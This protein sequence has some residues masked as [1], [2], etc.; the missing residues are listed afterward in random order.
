MLWCIH[1]HECERQ[2]FGGAPWIC[3][4]AVLPTSTSAD[5]PTQSLPQDLPLT[6]AAILQCLNLLTC[7]TQ[8]NN[9][10]CVDNAP[11]C[12]KCTAKAMNIISGHIS[13][14]LECSRPV[15]CTVSVHTK[16][17]ATGGWNFQRIPLCMPWFWYLKPLKLLFDHKTASRTKQVL[18]SAQSWSPHSAMTLPSHWSV[19][20]H[21]TAALLNGSTTSVTGEDHSPAENG[22]I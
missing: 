21:F 14:E 18:H 20:W 2:N 11:A 13:V 9:K 17:K 1:L 4:S 12:W 5:S 7:Y 10:W 19:S 6:I 22:R 15:H 8:V 3:A 16:R